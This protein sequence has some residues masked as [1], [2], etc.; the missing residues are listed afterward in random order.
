MKGLLTQLVDVARGTPRFFA[1]KLWRW[2]VRTHSAVDVGPPHHAWCPTCNKPWPCRE[3]MAA[4]D[5]VT[6]LWRAGQVTLPRP[7]ATG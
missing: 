7:S 6:K 4:T 3:W 1:L 2:I 5:E